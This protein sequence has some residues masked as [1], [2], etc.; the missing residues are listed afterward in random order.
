MQALGANALGN[1][2]HRMN[3]T[4]C[5]LL[6]YTMKINKGNKVVKAIVATSNKANKAKQSTLARITEMV[7][8]K[9]TEKGKA[10]TV[11]TVATVATT[12]TATEAKAAKAEKAKVEFAT[13]N[14]VGRDNWQAKG[15]G[16]NAFNGYL[17]GR[18]YK[19]NLAHLADSAENA[20]AAK[21]LVRE[22]KFDAGFY[23]TTGKHGT[24]AGSANIATVNGAKYA[25]HATSEM[26]IKEGAFEGLKFIDKTAILA[27][28]EKGA[29][30]HVKTIEGEAQRE[31]R[32][33]VIGSLNDA[34]ATL[35]YLA[36]DTLACQAL[37]LKCGT[38]EK[39]IR[40]VILGHVKGEA[41]T[42]L[43]AA[44]MAGFERK[45]LKA[46]AKGKALVTV[47]KK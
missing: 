18:D 47:A 9:A 17:L 8:G 1:I 5:A 46:G 35:V 31:F 39:A 26:C 45:Q 29:A 11:V 25:I 33:L 34:K 6:R 28:C 20:G 4:A 36:G 21:A 37:N 10:E 32:G 23:V 12:A 7:T 42:G 14:G 40:A 27:L 16:M 22:G 24:I 44:I 15:V 43:R 13:M 3:D 2:L 19:F 30:I 38:H 41:E